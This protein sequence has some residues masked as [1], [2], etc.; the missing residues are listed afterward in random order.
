MKKS[1]PAV[2]ILLAAVGLA[3]HEA[4]AATPLNPCPGDNAGLSLPRGFCASVF[5]DH[6]G[7]V[8]HLAVARDG[9]VYVNTW[10]G[11][12]YTYGHVDKLPEG[13]FLVALRDTH[14]AGKAD[15]IKRFGDGVAQ[16]SAGG[17]G[18]ALYN[19]ALYAEVND[20]IVRYS[21]PTEG[22]V[23]TGKYAVVVSGLPLG[24]DHPMHPFVIDSKGN[25]LVDVGTA[26]NACDVE[27][28][29]PNTKG[30]DPCTEL[31]TRGGIWR[32]DANKLDQKF[33]ASGRYATGIRNGEGMDFDATG[34]LFVTQH[35]RDQLLE[36]YP[37]LYDVKNGRELPAEEVFV[38]E[39]G[40]DYGW[41]RC[42]FDGFQRKLVLA[43]EYGGDGGHKVGVC[44]DK[45]GPAFFFPAHWA[46][47]DLVI[48]K[49][50]QFPKAYQGGAFVAFHGSW[51]RA[52]AP[53]GGYNVVFQ[54]FADGRATGQYVVFADG[55]AGAYREP[56]RALARPGGLAVG[57]DGSL[58]VSE[59]VH[60]TI[61]RITYTGSA[62]A[63]LQGAA[64]PVFA[65][66]RGHGI[67]VASL[68]VPAGATREQVLLG[69]RIFWGESSGGTC[70]G[71][72][73]S[74]GKGSTVGP[75]LTS[76]EWSW[77]DGSWQGIAATIYKGV[78]SPKHADGAMPPR[79]GAPLS[80]PDVKAVAAFV[81]GISHAAA[82]QPVGRS[83]Q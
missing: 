17:T 24:G 42:Y 23:P 12:Y 41:P 48:Y 35:G 67:D 14:G 4:H 58:Y 49:A 44:A 79:G 64:T 56:G 47:N 59:D 26:T 62:D 45:R 61:W 83:N 43:P 77:G 81:W 18:I 19:N 51:N 11:D 27:N 57:S 71:C 10:S 74:D 82:R 78:M 65:A 39:R 72:H 3:N 37:K 69:S 21:L 66:E 20:R 54:P 22:L 2:V 7:H 55:F 70:S 68:P 63:A 33:S 36:N 31:E 1:W 40:G 13:G 53:Q 34:R 80:D 73:G 8:R 9:T 5:A 6:L 16:G 38:L 50:T 60:G 25:L 28:R 75:N 46:P 76:G 30:H 32:F 15:Q 52:P 29:M